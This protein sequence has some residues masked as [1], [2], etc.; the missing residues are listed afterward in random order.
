MSTLGTAL[1]GKRLQ[2]LKET[3]PQST[4]IAVL[5]NPAFPAYASRL[6]NLT[7]A[8]QAMGLHLHVVEVPGD[9]DS[10]VLREF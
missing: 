9:H 2:I 10:M 3:V 4:H 7:M 1:P 5:A 6:H 8:A